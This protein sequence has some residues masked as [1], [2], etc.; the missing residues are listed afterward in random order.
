MCMNNKER[1]EEIVEV[2]LS[3]NFPKSMTDIKITI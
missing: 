1:A 2:I 3:E